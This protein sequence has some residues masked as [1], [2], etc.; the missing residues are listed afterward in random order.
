MPKL[1][2]FRCGFGDAS[3]GI[4]AG[5]G[6]DGAGETERL[7]EKEERRLCVITLGGFIGRAADVG[8][9]GADGTGEPTATP[10][11]A[12]TAARTDRYPISGGVGLLEDIRRGG[13]SVLAWLAIFGGLSSWLLSVYWP[14]F[15]LRE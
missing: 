6:I 13:R 15:V 8:V 2:L 5:S 4:T 9:P 7:D 11:T 10:G 3:I 14:S 1:V 12:S